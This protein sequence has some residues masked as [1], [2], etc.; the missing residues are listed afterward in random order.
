MGRIK[1]NLLDNN[2]DPPFVEL[3]G[4]CVEDDV[5]VANISSPY[6]PFKNNNNKNENN[7]FNNTDNNCNNNDN[8]SNNNNNTHKP[9]E[10]FVENQEAKPGLN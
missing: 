5:Y 1:F 3:L 8:N 4:E 7:N 10:V 6:V 9:K 2:F